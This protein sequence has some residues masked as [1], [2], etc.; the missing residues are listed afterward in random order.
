MRNL[1]IIKIILWV[2]LAVL[3][4]VALALAIP[5]RV[6]IRYTDD[7]SV[8]I[9]YLFLKFTV[10]GTEQEKKTKKRFFRKKKK[11]VKSTAESKKVTSKKKNVTGSKTINNSTV[12][13]KKT[14]VSKETIKKENISDTNSKKTSVKTES[15][16]KSDK[17]TKKKSEKKEENAAVKWIKDTFKESGLGGLLNA[18]KEIAKLAG[19][20]LKPIFKHIRIKNL[21]LNVTVAFEDAADTAVNYGYFCS[22]I[23]PALA[24]LLRIMK[25]DDYSVNIVPDFDK[26]KP[27]FDVFVNLSILPWFVVFGAVHALINYLILKYKGKL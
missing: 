14:A 4:I 12:S 22:G 5:V 16:K 19:T 27:E 25:Y 23:Y 10:V 18:F 9:K 15:R 26:K 13:E 2:L 6:R 24:I 11:T 1:I 7:V 21:D 3:L 17:K 20:F 8:V